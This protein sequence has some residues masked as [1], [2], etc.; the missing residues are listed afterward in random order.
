MFTTPSPTDACT[1]ALEIL[2]TF[3][4]D[5]ILPGLRAGLAYGEV[6]MRDGDYYGPVVNLAARAAAIARA[7]TVVV[8]DQLRQT[9]SDEAL[10]VEALPPR[11]LTG[12]GESITL[13]RV[14]RRRLPGQGSP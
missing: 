11:A 1:I 5:H 13:F 14:T 9:L 4:Q 10:H 7:G 6:V 12:F 8:S 3:A 2:D